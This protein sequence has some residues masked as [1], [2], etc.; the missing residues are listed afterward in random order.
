MLPLKTKVINIGLA[1]LSERTVFITLWLITIAIAASYFIIDRE[2]FIYYLVT[3]IV[4]QVFT[5]LV[6]GAGILMLINMYLFRKFPSIIDDFLLQ[7][8]KAL[9]TQEAY[10]YQVFIQW[11]IELTTKPIGFNSLGKELLITNFI[12]TEIYYIENALRFFIRDFY[13]KINND[14]YAT[15]NEIC[16]K[17]A[18]LLITERVKFD[19]FRK[20]SFVNRITIDTTVKLPIDRKKAILSMLPDI[21]ILKY[22]YSCSD[23][24]IF[25]SNCISEA[26]RKNLSR[27]ATLDLLFSNLVICVY[28]YKD[29]ILPNFLKEF[30]GDLAQYHLLFDGVP[31]A[32]NT[33]V[34][35]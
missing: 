24:N 10:I 19:I 25:L 20:D 35:H 8:D 32:E 11:Q 29:N 18:D 12:Q 31:L 26:R 34:S 5:F 6:F 17:F 9:F 2:R 22:V 15:C 4:N 3:F 30:N 33:N 7:R 16:D 13:E 1:L 21:F 27:H 14:T 23:F 28:S